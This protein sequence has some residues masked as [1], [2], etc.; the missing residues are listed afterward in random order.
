MRIKICGINSPSAYEAAAEAGADWVG[1]VF[2]DRSPR[3]VTPAQAARLNRPN[4]PSRV[5]LFVKPTD[6]DLSRA[7]DALPLDAVQLY[8]SNSRFEEIAS[9]F[10]LPL[11][12]AV[13]VGAT[14]DLPREPGRA[15]AFVIEPKPPAQADRP[16]GLAQRLDWRIVSGW[17]SS[18]PW[19]LAG[20]L[21]P[22]NV[23][24]AI[25]QTAADAVDVSSGVETEPGVKHPALIA[26]FVAA[27]RRPGPSLTATLGARTAQA[28]PRC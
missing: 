16:G 9:R 8:V 26:A 25:E 27:A 23:G 14:D 3:C 17:T 2:F 10:K 18:T 20:G 12:R 13:G 4:G 24:Q 21:T 28:A 1:F 19:L 5:G 22:L 7:L 15:A 6:D 11:W